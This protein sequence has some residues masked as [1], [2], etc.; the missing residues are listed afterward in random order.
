VLFSLLT[1]S[2]FSMLARSIGQLP[3][4]FW[5]N[6][7][8]GVLFEIA[9]DV[10][11]LFGVFRFFRKPYLRMLDTLERGW[12]VF[13][14]VPGL[15]MALLYGLQYY[16]VPLQE[17]PDNVPLIFIAFALTFVFYLI[18]YLNFENITQHY[19]LKHDRK[20]MM[21]Q[22]DMHKKE[23]EA[24]QENINATKIYRHDM[25]HYLNAIDTLLSDNN[26]A[27]ALKF[28]RRLD[29][30]LDNTVLRQYCENYFVNV[31]LSSYIK[32]AEDEKIS[33][34]YD[35][36]IPEKINIDPVEI[37][38]IF[39]NAIENAI[40]ACLKIDDA[41]RRKLSIISREQKGQLIIRV[42][43]QYVGEVR[44]D[45]ELP[46][47]DSPEQG[48]GT[49]S[50]AAIAQKNGGVFSFTAQDGVFNAMVSFNY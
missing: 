38:L 23:Y 29:G 21:L 48:T 2:I 1:V 4:I 33:V 32:K 45:G 41:D 37:G 49:K 28:I 43:N 13:C 40:N 46:V 12:G 11:L 10:L 31:I 30:S 8:V 9:A 3:Y 14:L 25:R 42:S 15:L 7:F 35:V 22:L 17:R 50:I 44:F 26:A 16:P 34:D 5:N 20:V 6:A 27:K 18:V 24:L 36:I 47:S 39:A 19:E